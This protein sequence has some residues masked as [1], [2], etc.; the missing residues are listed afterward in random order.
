MIPVLYSCH[1]S[2]LKLPGM[3]AIVA[4]N[5]RVPKIVDAELL[6]PVQRPILK[7]QVVRVPIWEQTDP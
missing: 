3:D 5:E 6:E 1:V 2:H 4:G 7:I